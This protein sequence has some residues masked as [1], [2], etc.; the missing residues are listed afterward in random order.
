MKCARC[1]HD[2]PQ[3]DRFCGRCGLAQSADGKPVDPLIGITVA[4]RY[5][6]ERRIGVGGMGTVYLGSHHR[7]GQKVAV[8]VLHERHASDEQLTL[9]FENEAMTYGRVHHPNLVSLHD[10]GRTPDGMFFMVLEYC[11]GMSLSAMVR[12]CKRLEPTLAVDVVSQIAQGLAAAH[13]VGIVHRDLKPENVVLMESRPGRYHVKLLDFG[14]AKSVDDDGPRLTQAGMVFGTPEYMS[15]EQARGEHVDARSDIY[16]LGAMLYELLTGR[17]PFYGSNKM[18][19]MHSQASDA[20]VPPR[21]KVPEADLPE[22]ICAIVLKCLE[23]KETAR[24]QTAEELIAAFDEALGADRL[25]PLP[26]PSPS[27]VEDPFDAPA[28]ARDDSDSSSWAAARAD[29]SE[30]YRLHGTDRQ[31]GLTEALMTASGLYRRPS[32]AALSFVALILCGSVGLAAWFAAEPVPQ[33]LPDGPVATVP[34]ELPDEPT[35]AVAVAPDPAP[36]APAVVPAAPKKPKPKARAAAKPKPKPAKVATAAKPKPKPAKKQARKRA[37]VRIVADEP[38]KA[39][40]KK[41]IGPAVAAA[42]KAL[43]AGEFADAR[44]TIEQILKDAPDNKKAKT[45][46]RQLNNTERA[47]ALGRLAYDGADCERTIETLQQVLRVSPGAKTASS[48]VSRCRDA[49]P[50]TTL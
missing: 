42:K 29:E 19:V 43:R 28:D 40:K 46:R 2:L 17:P 27:F 6:I 33:T 24:F 18:K 8:K 44:E 36:V 45:L 13:N 7:V 23:K 15:P 1:D 5:R 22:E 16:A 50:P 32:A 39:E 21:E 34:E 26:L 47:L 3:S 48:M 38:P 31:S 11:P 25:T 37:V 20:P 10:F 49:M 30:P 41:D 4:D 35:P 14:I 12:K 9:R